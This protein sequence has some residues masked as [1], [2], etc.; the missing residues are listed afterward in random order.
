MSETSR[1]FEEAPRLK[2]AKVQTGPVII[3]NSFNVMNAL[4]HSI[5]ETD[6]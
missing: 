5:G 6:L 4:F 2:G 3:E 1:L